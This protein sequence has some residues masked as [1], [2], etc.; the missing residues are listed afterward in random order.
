VGGWGGGGRGRAPPPPGPGPGS[1]GGS[2]FWQ[3]VVEIFRAAARAEAGRGGGTRVSAGPA[4]DAFEILRRWWAGW[5]SQVEPGRAWSS[6]VGSGRV[7]ASARGGRG[8]ET[9]AEAA[10]R[11]RR[12][13]LGR[14]R[15]R[16]VRDS[17]EMVG[18]MGGP[19][20]ARSSQVE[21]G[22]GL[23]LGRAGRAG[24]VGAP[25]SSAG[26]RAGCEPGRFR[27]GWPSPGELG[28]FRVASDRFRV[29][30]ECPGD[31]GGCLRECLGGCQVESPCESGGVCMEMSV[32]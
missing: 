23:G 5:V 22:L 11:R 14:P 32:F 28:R 15:G 26:G 18:G 24:V 4:V 21:P 25:G 29:T 2:R 6:Q 3:R 19:C 7:W 31:S 8:G 13:G 20:R 17:P 16:C 12:A 27:G 1:G 9:R 10:W 30:L